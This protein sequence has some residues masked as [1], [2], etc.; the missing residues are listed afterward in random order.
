VITVIF[1]SFNGEDTLTLMLDA[2]LSINPPEGGWNIVAVDNASTDRTKEI[3]LYYSDI[4]PITYLYQPKQGKSYALNMG[5]EHADGELVVFTD[6][7]IIPDR[8]WLV[9]LSRYANENPEYH[10]FPGRIELYWKVSPPQWI[11]DN[12]PLNICYAK[13]NHQE[14][15][16]GWQFAAGPNI[17]VRKS[18]LDKG[19][20]FNASLGP[21]GNK[22]AMGEDSSFV[23]DL[24]ANGYV[25]FFCSKAIVNHIIDEKQYDRRWVL[26][27]SARY[28]ESSCFKALFFSD[29]MDKKFPLWMIRS[30]LL[31]YILYFYNKYFG[32]KN[33]AIKMLWDCFYIIGFVRAYL[34]YSFR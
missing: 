4:L 7:D 5:I 23:N 31:K 22:Y 10:L 14:G 28:G 15:P 27:R 32:D 29:S 33:A 6:D 30:I 21:A 26:K 2:F 8:D 17:S 20:R 11:L 3:L 16:C 13:L 19:F 1:A 34:K 12:V 18:V 9:E 24:F 25:S